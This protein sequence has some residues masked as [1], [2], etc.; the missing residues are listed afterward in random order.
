VTSG[1][2]LLSFVLALA[3]AP[4]TSPEGAALEDTGR[5]MRQVVLA[6][7][8][9]EPERLMLLVND[10]RLDPPKVS[11]LGEWRFEW[12]VTALGRLPA[13]DRF[14]T[15]FR[16]F[17]QS[18]PPQNDPA[19]AV[20]RTLIRLWDYNLLRLRLDHSPQFADQM[21]DV[22]LCAEGKPGAEHRFDEDRHELDALGRPRK[23]NTIYIYD[24]E[25][26]VNPVEMVREV[27][28]EYGHATLP[29]MAGYRGTEYWSNG[30]LG[31]RLYLT[32]LRRDLAAGRLVR[33]DTLG[34][35]AEMLDGYL[36]R[37]ATPLLN[38]AAR[39][40]PD[41]A[42]LRRR[43]R[44]GLE[45]YLGLALWAEQILPERAFGRSLVLTGSQ[46]AEDYPRA[47]VESAAEVANWTVRVPDSL[48]GQAIWIPLG[49]GRLA[50]AAVLE[51][52]GDWARIRPGP[53]PVIVANQPSG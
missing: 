48:E 8:D 38:A 5:R 14:V 1:A 7:A 36:A 46:N 28:H 15:R 29:P 2:L 6:G 50:G 22:Y 51:R 43:D 21:V 13:Q 9:G 17:S 16:V 39:N 11:P 37:R 4:A 33:A 44:A 19:P 24:L 35:T 42:L 20:A 31:E 45:A 26:F 49:K 18:R 52:R 27:A 40:G 12:V 47:I 25:S 32:W 34:A 3:P 41:M 23:V 30:E 10:V 53:R